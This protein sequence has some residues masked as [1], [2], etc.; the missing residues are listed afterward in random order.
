MIKKIKSKHDKNSVFSGVR[1]TSIGN[2]AKQIIRFGVS[3]IL[4]RLLS[5]NDFGLLAMALVVMNFLDVFKTLGTRTA[6]IRAKE[7]SDELLSSVFFFNGSIGLLIF[8]GLFFFSPVIG[9]IYQDPKVSQ[10][11]G[12]MGLIFLITSFDA[13]PLALLNRQMYFRTI[14]GIE[15]FGSITYGVVSILLAFAGWKVWALVFGSMARS[16]M[17]TILSFI[18]S[19]WSPK[20]FFKW[21]EI[22]KIRR[23]SS[24]LT[25]DQ[26]L[27]YFVQNSDTFIIGRFLGSVSL[28]YYDLAF[29]LFR[30]PVSSISGSLRRVLLPA[31]SKK[32][33]DNNILCDKFVR[34]CSSIS[35]ITFP[36]MIGICVL[37]SPFVNTILGQKWEA[38]IPLIMILSPAGTVFS[39]SSVTG[40]IYTTKG[41]T[42]LLFYWNLFS[43][44]IIISSFLVGLIWGITGVATAYAISSILLAYP[45][46][47][48]PFKLIDLSVIKFF[49]S[50]RPYFGAS[51]L[52][53]LVL[54]CCRIF[55]EKVGFSPFVVL[56]VCSAIG[57][58]TYALTII[59]IRP[60]AFQDLQKLVFL[61]SN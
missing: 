8:I 15:L 32:Q 17:H 53:G 58:I 47:A 25:L 36:L 30:Y 1:W 13:V 12:I 16:F 45:S 9:W 10:I 5:P 6:L 43:S 20:L 4:A 42:D 59:I 41:R 21:S 39:I 14:V 48:I 50:L 33:D 18:F 27:H 60:P 31:F 57:I 7:I 19:E 40:I 51:V 61:N 46:F 11:I 23:F 2:V 38:S 24:F 52:M 56:V 35:L 26:T 22:N 55:L 37:A 54:I 34:A 44:T 29:R 3:I 49:R 28:G